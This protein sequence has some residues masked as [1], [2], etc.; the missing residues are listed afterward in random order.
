[1]KY[2]IKHKSEV[3]NVKAYLERNGYEYVVQAAEP[4]CT[5]YLGVFATAHEA[6]EYA[7]EV[8]AKFN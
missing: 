3:K 4:D 1:M 2:T 8:V 5:Q 6:E 7:R